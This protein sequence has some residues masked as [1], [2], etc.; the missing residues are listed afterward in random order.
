MPSYARYLLPL[1]KVFTFV[2]LF[3]NLQAKTIM[4]VA[5]F[6]IFMNIHMHFHN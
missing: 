6:P 3:D 5:N 4:K 1:K 2:S